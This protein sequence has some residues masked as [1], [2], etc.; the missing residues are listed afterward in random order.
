MAKAVPRR[1]TRV[2]P[3]KTYMNAERFRIAD[4]LLR[5]DTNRRFLPSVASPAIILSAFASEL[6]L[7]CILSLESGGRHILATHELKTLYNDLRIDTRKRLEVMWAE[8]NL[9][10][11]N[12]RARKAIAVVTGETIPEDLD[13]AISKANNAF[14]QLRYIHENDGNGVG[15]IIHDLPAM[16]KTV[17]LDMQPTWAV[18]GHGQGRPVPGFEEETSS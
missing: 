14:V 18:F 7:K 16:L 2:D 13:W 4:A 3:F 10:P 15:F 1:T 12:V 11:M 8:S 17:I 5:A 9:K 6:Y